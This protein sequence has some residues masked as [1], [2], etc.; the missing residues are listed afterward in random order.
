MLNIDRGP[1]KT[2]LV[3]EHR[4]TSVSLP[5]LTDRL[6][7]FPRTNREIRDRVVN[8]DVTE[9]VVKQDEE[10]RNGSAI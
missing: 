3:E 7:R 5:K 10:L 9:P 6:N 1:G 8:F 4:K 2:H